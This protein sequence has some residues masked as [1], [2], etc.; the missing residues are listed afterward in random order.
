MIILVEENDVL[1]SAEMMNRKS[2]IT[3]EQELANTLNEFF[4]NVVYNLQ[5][6]DPLSNNIDNPTLK[7]IVKWRN[8]PMYLLLRLFMEMEL[9]FIFL[10][11]N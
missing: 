7:V 2:Q 8:H 4:A 3:V 11:L 6:P 5:I 1:I 9:Q 10:P